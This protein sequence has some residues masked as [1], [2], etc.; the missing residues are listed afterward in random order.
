MITQPVPT[1]VFSFQ[2]SREED[3]PVHKHQ[4]ANLHEALPILWQV[5]W[6]DEDGSHPR[7]CVVPLRMRSPPARSHTAN[8]GRS[9][10]TQRTRQSCCISLTKLIFKTQP[11][12]E[13]TCFS[14][15]S[16]WPRPSPRSSYY[17]SLR[18]WAE[19]TARAN[20]RFRG[21]YFTL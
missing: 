21:T 1:A 3:I 4:A 7:R 12:A 10:Q 19:T 6:V 18:G 15:N 13:K 11:A 2:H 9:G 16:G 17:F 14:P 20:G 5:V 8:E